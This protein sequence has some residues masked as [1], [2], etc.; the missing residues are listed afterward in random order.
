MILILLP[1]KSDVFTYLERCKTS[2]DIIFA[3]PPLLWTKNVRK[4]IL[5][6]FER[7]ALMKRE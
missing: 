1:Q 3:D 6:V 4:I 5:L 2:Y 7:T